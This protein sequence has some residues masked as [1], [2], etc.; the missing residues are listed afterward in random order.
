[1][2]KLLL[3]SVGVLLF[4]RRHSLRRMSKVAS[5]GLFEQ[6]ARRNATFHRHESEL[7][8]GRLGAGLCLVVGI[9][10]AGL[11]TEAPMRV[12]AGEVDGSSAISPAQAAATFTL[13]V[14]P[15]LEVEP[16]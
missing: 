12:L 14:V 8:R 3:G 2:R 11:S 1:M 4:F 6:S 16:A 7:R 9:S 5:V 15:M 13:F 10:I